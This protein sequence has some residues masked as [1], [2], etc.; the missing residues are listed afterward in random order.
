MKF[1]YKTTISI[2]CDPF[3]ARQEDYFTYICKNILGCEYYSPTNTFFGCWDWKVTY[4]SQEQR[5]QIGNYLRDLSASGHIRY[6][7]W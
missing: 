7:S 1:P 6:A 5:D 4:Q 2:D 3:C